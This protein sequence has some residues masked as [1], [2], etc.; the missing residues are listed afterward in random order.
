LIRNSSNDGYAGGNNLGLRI[1]VERGAEYVMILNN[2]VVVARDCLE[3][4]VAAARSNPDAALVGPLVL[5]A[6]APDRIQSAG[7]AL[8]ENW[9]AYH[10]GLN[11]ADRGQFDCIDRVDWLSGCAVL[12]RCSDLGTIGFLDPDFYMYAEDVDWGVRA[13]RS[14][15]GVLFAPHARVWHKGVMVEY[16]PPAYV[17]Y[18]MARNELHL[19]RK[20]HG[21]IA[22][23]IGAITRDFRTLVSWSVRPKWRKQR[24]H[25]DALARAL[26]DFA[27]GTMG[28]VSLG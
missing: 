12:A 24:A 1:A 3:Q 4:L 11:E 5:Y 25:R 23:L 2:D 6:D 8:P 15:R 27:R 17:T 16:A 14:G 18:Y 7:G 21:G 22:P 28:R 26:R 10:R 19:I 20:H 9:H 13:R